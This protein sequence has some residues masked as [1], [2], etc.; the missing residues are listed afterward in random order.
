M[1]PCQFSVMKIAMRGDGV[2]IQQKMPSI[3]EAVVIIANV[4]RSGCADA[5]IPCTPQEH[6][7][8]N[9]VL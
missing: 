7:C 6:N 1:T 3:R 8:N 9:N 2:W 4:S 5:G